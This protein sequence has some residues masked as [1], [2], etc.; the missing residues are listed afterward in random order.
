M[1]TSLI[2]F[3]NNLRVSD[4]EALSL[5]SKADRLIA[6]YFFDPRQY[7]IGPFGFKKTERFRA[8]FLLET[9]N[10]LQKK[11][12]DLNITLLV[13]QDK[14]EKGI[15]ELVERFQ[16]DTIYL[17]KEWTSEEATVLTNVK[18]KVP[19][20]IEFHETFDQFLFHPEDI[21]FESYDKIPQVFTVFRKKCEKHVDVRPCFEVP[22][23]FPV[24]N[25][26]DDAPRIP[27]L[28]ELG[29]TDFEMDPRSAFPFG[30]GEAEALQRLQHYFWDTNKL[31]YYKKT[32][33]GLVG[34]DYSSKFS[35]SLHRRR[36]TV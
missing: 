25:R 22:Q 14:P 34:T 1:K 12:E 23:S 29:F 24:E 32:R 10:Q 8:K 19:E 7:K 18:R 30:G 3:G 15:P 4:N 35:H 21:P 5:A 17:Q 36:N 31:A 2:W 28:E 9:V 20:N 16:I 11:L 27:T 13:Y 26:M 33:N 6:V